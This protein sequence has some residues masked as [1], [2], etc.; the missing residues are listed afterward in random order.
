MG[1]DV[2]DRRAGGPYLSMNGQG[3]RLQTAGNAEST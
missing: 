1:R 3:S 2:P